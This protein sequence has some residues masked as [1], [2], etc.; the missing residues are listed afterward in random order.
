MRGLSQ[1]TETFDECSPARRGP[2]RARLPHPCLVPP[3]DGGDRGLL[4]IPVSARRDD[5][6]HRRGRPLDCECQRRHGEATDDAS[7]AGNA[8]ADFAGRAP[9][10]LRRL[11][12]WPARRLRHADRRRRAEAADLR[13]A[14]CDPVRLVAGWARR[15]RERQ[16]RRPELALH[17]AAGRPRDRRGRGVAAGRCQ[18][19]RA[20]RRWHRLLHPFR[21]ARHR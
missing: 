15:V 17:A 4:P 16:R 2:G 9:G 1:A 7:G 18:R 20:R 10:R 3:R 6:L 21:P 11:L 13:G 19:D 14:A 5:R 12:R 8:G